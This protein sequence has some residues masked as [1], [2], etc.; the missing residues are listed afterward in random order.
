LAGA[1][2]AND[3]GMIEGGAAARLAVEA[4]DV[5]LVVEVLGQDLDGD[6]LVLGL[7]VTEIDLAHAAFAEAA[8]EAVLSQAAQLGRGGSLC[9]TARIK[10]GRVHGLTFRAVS[11]PSPGNQRARQS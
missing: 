11:V 4:G 10:P 8:E 7:D 5:V 6:V 9:G 1:D 3:V 2:G